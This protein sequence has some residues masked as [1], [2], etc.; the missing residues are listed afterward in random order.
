MI[1]YL[2]KYHFDMNTEAGQVLYP[3]FRAEMARRGLQLSIRPAGER[4][5]TVVCAD[6]W[7]CDTYRIAPDGA[8]F[9][10]FVQYGTGKRIAR[11]YY[12]HLGEIEPL[13]AETA[14]RK[15]SRTAQA[16]AWVMSGEER[17]P[18]QAA[19]LF[20]LTPG[21]I[22]TAAKRAGW[23]AGLARR[24]DSRTAQAITWIDAEPGRTQY[25]AARMFGI[26]QSGISLA[27]QR[28]ADK[29]ARTDER[30]VT[31]DERSIL[32]D[33]RYVQ[34]GNHDI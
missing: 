9:Y 10:D 24:M 27:M 18:Y 6:L 2:T 19:K 8:K 13:P 28:R 23:T 15:D 12:L 14:R 4:V 26:A 7:P 32:P 21:P 3:R 31:A 11:G 1:I 5:P 30:S 25:R 22:Y 16:V 29:V 33:E 20:G 17:T 34:E